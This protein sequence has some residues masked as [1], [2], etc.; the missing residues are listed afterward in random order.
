MEQ[1]FVG[2]AGIEKAAESIAVTV[3][4]HYK[5]IVV[6]FLKSKEFFLNIALAHRHRQKMILAEIFAAIVA[7]TAKRLI[8]RSGCKPS[9]VRHVH[10]SHTRRL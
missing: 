5:V 10:Y 6:L 1:N 7:Q 3:G 9:A 8:G 4:H 2:K